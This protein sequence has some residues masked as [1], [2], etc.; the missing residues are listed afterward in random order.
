MERVSSLSVM[1]HEQNCGR[2]KDQP[3]L[4]LVLLRYLSEEVMG[5]LILVGVWQQGFDL[6]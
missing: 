6:S 2:G 5:F 3:Y 1:M 4:R